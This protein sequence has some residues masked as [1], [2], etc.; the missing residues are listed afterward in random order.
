MPTTLVLFVTRDGHSHR[1][2]LRG[3]RLALLASNKVSP[4]PRI[5]AKYDAEF[6]GVFGP[7]A[8]FA[9]VRETMEEPERSK[10]IFDFAAAIGRA[11]K[12]DNA[13]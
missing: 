10:I 7:L 6:G 8:A 13:S 12:I 2:H 4:P 3:A 1:D 5:L 11:S 9:V